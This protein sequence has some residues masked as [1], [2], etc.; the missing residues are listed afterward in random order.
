MDVSDALD[1]VEALAG[2]PIVVIVPVCVEAAKRAGLPP[3]F[4]GL[5]AV[6]SATLL[7]ALADLTMGTRIGSETAARWLLLG[8]I[9]GL[10]GAGLY[11]QVHHLVMGPS[12]RVGPEPESLL[13]HVPADAPAARPADPSAGPT[14]SRR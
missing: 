2:V 14:G 7:V 8:A 10:A 1:R 9:H 6:A 3:R 13:P 12:A 5:A 11:S 4:A